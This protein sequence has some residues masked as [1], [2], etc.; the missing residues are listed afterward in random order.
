M[1]SVELVVSREQDE[2]LFMEFTCQYQDNDYDYDED[3]LLEGPQRVYGD[4]L[5]GAADCRRSA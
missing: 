1:S 3:D 4:V 2:N 5:G